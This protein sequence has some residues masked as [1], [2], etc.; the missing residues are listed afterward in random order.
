MS[1]AK[2]SDV[3]GAP[4]GAVVAI[5]FQPRA[6][7]R[8]VT[9]PSAHVAAKPAPSDADASASARAALA[10]QLELAHVTRRRRAR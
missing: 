6:P 10:A 2:S 7:A 9:V 4:S 3:T 1:A 5:A 8:S